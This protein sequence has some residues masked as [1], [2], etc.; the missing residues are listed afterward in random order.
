[1][2]RNLVELAWMWPPIAIRTLRT[3]WREVVPGFSSL[4]IT[5]FKRVVSDDRAGMS[6]NLSPLIDEEVL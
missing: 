1:V 5:L 2:T 6:N 3:S 4:E